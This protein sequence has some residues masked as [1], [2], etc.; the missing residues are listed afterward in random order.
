MSVKVKKNIIITGANGMLGAALSRLLIKDYNIYALHRSIKFYSKC[1]H[2]IKIDLIDYK[3][4]EQIVYAIKPDFV[5]HCASM[6]NI[7]EC[8]TNSEK[9]YVNNTTVTENIARICNQAKLI[10]ISTDQVY[11]NTKD[12][13]EK[14]IDLRPVNHYGKTKYWGERKV[15][16][17]CTEYIIIRTNIFGWNLNP[18]RVG[19]AEWIYNSLTN[20]ELITL[21]DDYYF[22]PI[23]TVTLGEIIMKLI[24]LKYIGILNI[25]SP[26]PCNKY[27][28]G[29]KMAN[30][31]NLNTDLIEKGK[32]INQKFKAKRSNDITLDVS[33]AMRLNIQM[34]NWMESMKKLKEDKINLQP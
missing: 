33:A 2:D 34:L 10:Y 32:L 15:I 20:D 29:I 3:K 25:G 11:G 6:I 9:A 23:Y 27:T 31:F 1:T 22:T 13:S 24:D 17:N 30:L 16:N 8:E 28:F 7:E 4:L 26:I 19:F 21:F 12:K 14:N 5:I 18:K